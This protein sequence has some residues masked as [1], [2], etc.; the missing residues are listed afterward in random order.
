MALFCVAQ[1]FLALQWHVE[2]TQ[3]HTHAHWIA[4]LLQMTSPSYSLSRPSS[5]RSNFNFHRDFPSDQDLDPKKDFLGSP[6]RNHF[7]TRRLFCWGYLVSASCMMNLKEFSWN[8]IKLSSKN[9][10]WKEKLFWSKREKFHSLI[11]WVFIQF[12]FLVSFWKVLNKK[13]WRSRV[14]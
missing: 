1:G 12:R 10:W 8:L 4:L 7:K 6:A 11:N 14:C 13:T 2:K 5:M 3:Q 9:P